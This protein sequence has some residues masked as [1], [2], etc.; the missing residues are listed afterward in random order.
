MT[1]STI[2]LT[3]TNPELFPVDK[4]NRRTAADKLRIIREANACAHGQLGALLRK[5][6][7]YSSTLAFYRTQ[8][9]QG[10]LTLKTADQKASKR[11]ENS[12]KQQQ[13]LQRNAILERE[14]IKLKALVELQKKVGD[15]FRITMENDDLP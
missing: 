13:L 12:A 14:N 10:K 11:K 5:E 9:A 8:L 3:L 6:G 4:K 7:I 2:P 15:L 1:P